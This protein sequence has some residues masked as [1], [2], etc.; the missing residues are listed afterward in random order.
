MKANLLVCLLFT[1]MAFAQPALYEQMLP[2]STP[3]MTPGKVASRAITVH[4]PRP[5]FI[6]GDDA[7]SH[8]WLAAY[9]SQLKKM[10]AVGMIVNVRTPQGLQRFS[11]YPLQTYPIQ[12]HDVMNTFSLSHYPVLIHDG[13]IT[14][15]IK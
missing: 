15:I 6:V 4:V 12:G 3:Q 5:L 13:K 9:A 2:V 10:N 14:Q 7:L 8:R 11:R 1:Q